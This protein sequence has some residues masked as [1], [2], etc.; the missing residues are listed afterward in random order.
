M[1]PSSTLNWVAFAILAFAVLCLIGYTIAA[2]I[3]ELREGSHAPMRAGSPP[4]GRVSLLPN[5]RSREPVIDIAEWKLPDTRD[6]RLSLV[7]DRPDRP[8]PYR[9]GDVRTSVAPPPKDAA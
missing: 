3:T 7:D 1:S 6:V 4:R 2:V 9:I 5:T 8:Y